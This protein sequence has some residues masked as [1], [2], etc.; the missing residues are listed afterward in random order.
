MT[1]LESFIAELPR[2][3]RYAR[4][5]VKNADAADDLVQDC[6]ERS[7]SRLHQF[8]DG[9]DMRLW[10]FTIMHSIF[11]NG[12]SRRKTTVDLDRLDPSY[13]ARLATPPEQCRGLMKRDLEVALGQLPDNQRE[14]VILVGLENMTYKQAAEITGVPIGTVMSR[15]AR[16]RERLGQLMNGDD[17]TVLRRAK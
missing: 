6:V 8:R 17:V 4:A 12:V 1:K 5:L 10:L 14:M 13:E 9:T 7:L 16:G 11:V 2:L 3:R 15:L